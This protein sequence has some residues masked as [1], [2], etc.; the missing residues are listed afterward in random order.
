MKKK[1]RPP[2]LIVRVPVERV[3]WVWCWGEPTR[4]VNCCWGTVWRTWQQWENS[5][6]DT[7]F[8]RTGER[9]KFED[10]TGTNILAV[11]T[12]LRRAESKNRGN[13]EEVKITNYQVSATKNEK[14]WLSGTLMG[15]LLVDKA[16]PDDTI[17]MNFGCC[18]S[19]LLGIVWNLG[20]KKLN[21]CNCKSSSHNSKQLTHSL[22]RNLKTQ[23]YLI[24]PWRK[25]STSLL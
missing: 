14:R 2:T 9:L 3:A 20:N 24:L 10:W 18:C 8:R 16:F 21:Q 11:N 5:E 25:S 7:N 12:V 6:E 22:Q 23:C 13:G 17:R 15:V 19:W 4:L 1:E